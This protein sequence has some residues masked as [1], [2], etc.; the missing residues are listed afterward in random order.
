L[1]HSGGSQTANA[2]DVTP[3]IGP[4]LM[5]VGG[6]GG[7]SAGRRGRRRWWC[8]GFPSRTG[9]GRGP[10][11]GSGWRGRRGLRPSASLD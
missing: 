10:G 11:R 9:R 7:C 2:I 1:T 8:S 3:I 5:R 6:C 4:G